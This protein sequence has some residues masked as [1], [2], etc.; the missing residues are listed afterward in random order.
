MMRSLG[1]GSRL[2]AESKYQADYA[3]T[4]PMTGRREVW[5]DSVYRVMEDM[6][7]VKFADKMCPELDVWFAEITEAYKSKLIL[8]AQRALQFGGPQLLC[9]DARMYN[10]VSTFADRPE[11]F[12]EF[13]WL[14]LC[15]CGCGYSVQEQHVAKLPSLRRRDR[16]VIEVV[17]EDSIEGWADAMGAMVSS[18]MDYDSPFS[19]HPIYFNLSK[20]R[21][22]GAYI[23][24]G[25]K[26]P[27]PAPLRTALDRME[28]LLNKVCELG[29][30]TTLTVYDLASVEADAVVAGG[31]RRAAT[32]C[33][34]SKTDIA[35]RDAKIGNWYET[36]PWRARSNNSVILLRSDVSREEFHEIMLST[37]QYGEP[38]FLFVDTL[39][40]TVNPCVE[41]GMR[42]L[43]EDGRTG[44]QACNLTEINGGACVDRETFL[45]ACRTASAL[46]TLQAAYTNL[47]YLTDASREIIRREALIG[48]GITGWMN[49]P[50]V[51][52]DPDL[53]REGAEVVKA[54]NREVAALIGINPSARCTVVKPSGNSSVLLGTASG[55]HGEHAPR[56]IR[57]VQMADTSDVL[58]IL[59]KHYPELVDTSVWSTARTDKVVSFPII[60]PEG[61]VFKSGLVGVKQ[62]KYVELAQRVW[63]ECGKNP[64][65]CVDPRVSHN[66]SNTIQV[67]DDGEDG[68]DAVEAYLYE[69]RRWFCGVSLLPLSGDKIYNQAPFTEVLTPEEHVAK[70]GAPGILAAGLVTQALD[71]FGDLWTATSCVM[72]DRD[73][74]LPVSHENSAK[75]D[76]GRRI[77]KFGSKYF[78]GDIAK[79]CDCLKDAHLIHKWEKIMRACEKEIDIAA[80][81]G[82]REE[83]EVGTLVGVACSGDACTRD[84]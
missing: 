58:H 30:M 82:D 7:R 59:E 70:Y 1:Y 61:S 36:H 81:L 39:D 55:I 47:T 43:T 49:N 17:V 51:L 21:P 78:A 84:F 33:F 62:L 32:I 83:V 54:V 34:F 26:A 73:E 46:G 10:C 80:E 28:D 20:I 57:N 65:L 40:M 79:A 44:W 4:N 74:K 23:S 8:G 18:F 29:K 68:W 2:M 53:M 35:M 25:F 52:F 9:K 71:A 75:I 24:G 22:K 66:V 3:R 42:P 41:V 69:N 63:I 48:V 13:A 64:E 11:F 45:K 77:R 15:G 37:K 12:R 31:V 50:T 5:E 76:I 60:P 38:G 27:G 56:Y 67:A 72:S 14:L 6:H 16:G 19:G